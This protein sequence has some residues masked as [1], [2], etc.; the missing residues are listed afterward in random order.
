MIT[1]IEEQ[2]G[3]VRGFL[4]KDCRNPCMDE[5]GHSIP[6]PF[7]MDMDGILLDASGKEYE[8]PR[9]NTEDSENFE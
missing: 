2:L 1:D 5:L 6:K 4:W 7:C 3:I 8:F 9:E